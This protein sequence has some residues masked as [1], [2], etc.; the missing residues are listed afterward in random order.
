MSRPIRL[1]AAVLLLLVGCSDS[2]SLVQPY[3][4]CSTA[5]GFSVYLEEGVEDVPA[6]IKA[7]A[8]KHRLRVLEVFV[9]TDGFDARM[10]PRTAMRVGVEHAVASVSPWQCDNGPLQIR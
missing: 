3:V 2:A 9:G 7:L 4:D 8:A 6:T 10:S 5:N 1:V